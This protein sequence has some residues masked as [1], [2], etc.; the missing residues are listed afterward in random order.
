VSKSDHFY[1]LFFVTGGGVPI[2]FGASNIGSYIN[3]KS[4]V[5]CNVNR[6]VIEEMRSFYPRVLKEKRRFTFNDSSLW[7]TQQQLLEWADGYLRKELEPCIQR[8]IELDMND[9]AYREVLNQPFIK[10]RAIM[11]GMY[12]FQGIEMV[13]DALKQRLTRNST[14]VPKSNSNGVSEN[15]VFTSIQRGSPQQ[16]PDPIQRI[17]LKIPEGQKYCPW[18]S[19]DQIVNSPCDLQL[20]LRYLI[21]RVPFSYAHFNDGE[22][23][24][25]Q[26]DK[27]KTDRGMQALSP[28]L[29]QTMRHA[30]YQ[31]RSG[32]V[33]GLPC[34]LQFKGA[35][36]Y[37]MT[38]LENHT[39]VKKTQATLFI[40]RNYQVARKVLLAYLR[41]NQS[42]WNAR[43]IYLVV[44]DTADMELFYNRTSLD[45]GS[46]NVIRVPSSNA[47]PQGYD[48]NVNKH[49]EFK[50]N[51][52]V[53]ICAGPL[54]RILAV[55]WYVLANTTT[56]LEL[57][58]FFDMDLYGKSFGASYYDGDRDFSSCN[59]PEDKM[60]HIQKDRLLGI[61]AKVPDD[62]M[63]DL[64]KSE[65]EEHH[66]NSGAIN[67]TPVH[68]TDIHS[69]TTIL[70]ARKFQLALL[71]SSS[72]HTSQY[73]IRMNTWHRN[74]QL[75]I[76]INHHA[77]CEGVASIQI[78]WCDDENE[79]PDEVVHHKSG[80]VVIERHEI[81]SLNERYR[82]LE[83]TPTIAV[84]SLDDDVLRPCEALDAAFIRWTRHPD[85]IVGFYP[86]SVM[87][88]GYDTQWVYSQTVMKNKYSITLPTKSS[89]IHRDYLDL[90]MAALPRAILQHIDTNFNCEDIAMSYFVSA[91]TEGKPP[92]LS[93][94]WAIASQIEL[95]SENGLSRKD[96]HMVSPPNNFVRSQLLTI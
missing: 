70:D 57:G 2:Y 32:L 38:S 34:R 18:T 20:L 69:I 35:H 17:H 78:I 40:D 86:R 30:F 14:T 47:F 83:P 22:M 27:G 45:S 93:D 76:S 7:P 3:G 8:V 73:T 12:P 19:N 41:M 49:L 66:D 21:T 33:Y 42:S 55:E 29:Q 63:H 87:G 11:D 50:Q 91:M 77:K 79:P 82:I 64:G 75:L 84:L 51:D 31:N 15:D 5:H 95:H 37:A 4:I 90:Y 36:E 10:N 60:W 62:K 24:A 92:L 58:S 25:L 65:S 43:K 28:R 67:P 13:Q 6:S 9:T 81:N 53:M 85:R 89:F 16:T 71:N 94:H 72:L 39:N 59:D 88:V 46:I 1:S 61:I 56:I 96:E 74:E 54:G 23:S 80:K 68:N 44:G 26:R 52:I 48:E